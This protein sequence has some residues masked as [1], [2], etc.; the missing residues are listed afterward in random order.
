[1]A[2]KSLYPV[3]L[4]LGGARTRCLVCLLENGHI[5]F[6]GS[7]EVPS[8]GWVKGR[9][10]DQKAVADT[11]LAALREAERQAQVSVE[12]AVVGMGGPTV[13]GAN[14]RGVIELGR[15]REI[16]QRDVNRVVNR[17]SFVQLM[18]DRMVLQ[19]F[20]QDFVVDDHPGHRDPRG[21]LA[22]R[23]EAN[24]HLI[25][26]STQEHQS[27]VGAVNLA[28][29]SVEETVFEPLA[30]CYAA[31][32]PDDRR[33]GIALVDIG[34]QSTDL[35]VYYGDALQLA[36]TLALCGDHFTRD[37]AMGLCISYED[38]ELVKRQFGCA[39]SRT[40]AENSI[41]ELPA[42]ENREPREA[43]RRLLN[44]IL[45]ARAE[46]LFKYVLRELA[47]VGMERA[48]IGGVVLTGGATFLPGICD[49]AEAVL[50]CQARKGLPVGIAD[51]PEEI[52]NASWTV[53]AGLAM[54]SANLKRQSEM[55]KQAA[56]LLGRI[57]SR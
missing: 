48:L 8:Q 52:D 30:A 35:V 38:A 7:S 42:V 11:V 14:A 46:E 41:V 37:L 15:P 31:V 49:V 36:S 28:H 17:A 29:L 10:V 12:A 45:E 44:Q 27:L 5:R 34:A 57:L 25:T 40:T 24:A 4:D 51:W 43:P 55:E 56:G 33:E 16:E 22:S 50:N 32:L 9:I 3:G 2:A 1:M 6:L 54:Y 23:L 19:L 39:V 47:R 21:M 26:A 20:P 53:A 13:R 18:D